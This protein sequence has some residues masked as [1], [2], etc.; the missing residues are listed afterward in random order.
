MERLACAGYRQY[1]VSAYARSGDQCR[2]NRNYWE[3]GDYLGVGAGA[4]GKLSLADG[5][6]LRR[7]KPRSP[8]DYA[9]TAG[10]ARGIAGEQF[11][12]R[13]DLCFEFMLNALRLV[14]GVDSAL[15]SER[16]GMNL[17]VVRGALERARQLGLLE[18]GGLRPTELGRRFLNDLVNLFAEP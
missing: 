9:A 14:D 16:T 15:F 13:T 4:H 3:F 18:A 5:R 10:T 2:H 17:G 8:R 12:G 11:L 1:E 6:V 7:W